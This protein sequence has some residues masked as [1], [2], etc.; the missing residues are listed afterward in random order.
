[1]KNCNRLVVGALAV[2]LLATAC[3]PY[4][5]ENTG[6]PSIAA[7][8]ATDGNPDG[9]AFTE[10]TG[11]GSTWTIA[12]IPSTCHPLA[13]APISAPTGTVLA[14]QYAI[15]VTADKALSGPSIENP[16]QSCIPAGTPRW[17]TASPTPGGQSWFSC[18]T[19]SSPSVNLGGSVVI[20]KTAAYSGSWNTVAT[21]EGDVV[22]PVSY[23]MAGS[24]SDQQGHA[25]AM[26]V[27]ATVAPGGPVGQTPGLTATAS[28]TAGQIDLAWGNGACGG[29]PTYSVQRTGPFATT[30]NCP[31]STSTL[32][33]T[34]Q[35]G[36]TAQAFSDTG[37]TSGQKYCYR[38]F[39][40]VGTANGAKSSIKSATAP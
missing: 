10:G 12:G 4:A 6:P 30:A 40:T 28:A 22:N 23:T 37:L 9:A 16:P 18:Y 20:F 32:W 27:T 38:V 13:T 14:D 24:V 26:N 5:S 36:L 7:V 34:T 11:S 39:V 19:P 29:T 8:F 15:F 35:T 33:V 2:G 3:D 25:L 31:G 17:L 1:M 21:L